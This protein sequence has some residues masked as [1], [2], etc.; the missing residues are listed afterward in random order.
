[1]QKQFFLLIS[2]S[3]IL[4]SCQ[5]PVSEPSYQ[6]VWSD[7]FNQEDS[8]VNTLN[9]V[10]ETEAPENGNWYNNELQHYTDRVSNSY[11]SD[12]TL[13]IVAK[14]ET[15]TH[16]ETTK[17]YTSARLNSNFAFTYGKIE[18]RAKLPGAQGTWP[19]IW[20]LGTAIK[21]IGWP[22][23]GE[24]DIMEQLFE[25]HESVQCAIHT[26]AA[27]GDST[28]LKKVGTSDVRESYHVYGLEWTPEA[29]AFSV[30]DSVFFTYN[31]QPH[32]ADNWPFDSDQYILLNVAMG[33]TLGGP[34]DSAFT[35]D[36]MEVDYVRVYQKK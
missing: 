19:A 11:V 7:E 8:A 22:K 21:D 24:I 31:P 17:D 30:D 4:T 6:L 26:Q 23:A 36:Q 18:V 34:V 28:V 5:P 2:L 35:S 15:F 27:Y 25:D 12:G 14:K 3:T 1:M 10:H 9:W 29:L 13:K 33:G 20:T 32:T 16:N